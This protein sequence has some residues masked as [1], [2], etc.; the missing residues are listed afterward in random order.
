M[1]IINP[2]YYDGDFIRTQQVKIS[3]RQGDFEFISQLEVRRGSLVMV[4]MT[5]IGQ[6]LF[7]IQYQDQQI[8]FDSFGMPVDFDP[9]YLLSDIGLIY[10]RAD[11]ISECLHQTGSALQ[12]VSASDRRREFK[13]Q[14]QSITIDYL[15]RNQSGLEKIQYSNTWLDYLI[16]IHSLEIERL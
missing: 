10:S 4:A 11:A 16:N 12:I 1:P 7:Q 9:A 5:P 14:Q 2:A 15:S 3:S 8:H 13:N 6:K